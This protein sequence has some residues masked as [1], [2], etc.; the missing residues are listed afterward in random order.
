MRKEDRDEVLAASG[1]SPHKALMNGYVLS[2]ECF[3]IIEQGS[4]LPLGMF[5]Y[6]II[7]KGLLGTVWMLATDRLVEHRWS[8]LRGSRKRIDYMQSRVPLLYNTVDVRNDVHIKWLH[9]LGFRFVRVIKAGK[10]QLP[11]AE[12]VRL[13]HV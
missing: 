7:E 11:F 1:L 8:F 9:W 3:T 12:F 10:A 2:T 5:G 13:K 6:R 4:G